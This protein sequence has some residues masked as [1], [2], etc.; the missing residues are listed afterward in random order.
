MAFLTHLAEATRAH[1]VLA[2]V[3]FS[4]LLLPLHWLL[5]HEASV[6]MAAVVMGVIAGVYIGYG[7]ADG[8]SD[9]IGIEFLAAL[10]FGAGGL[11]GALWQPWVICAVLVLHGLWDLAHHRSAKGDPQGFGA[12]IP[13]YYIP[14]CLAVDWVVA[15]GLFTI[16]YL[17]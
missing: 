9:R 5:P 3:V 15:A 10:A 2:G 11:L 7:F 6:T 17:V 16:W 4:A 13:L 14:L 1:P 8:R 12:K